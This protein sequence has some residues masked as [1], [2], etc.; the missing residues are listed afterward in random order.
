[1]IV[2]V[3]ADSLRVNDIVLVRAFPFDARHPR[4]VEAR[5]AAVERCTSLVRTDSGALIT[6]AA[7]RVRMGAGWSTVWLAA[8][9]VALVRRGT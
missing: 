1:M 9:G 4:F 7:V 2:S 8:E 6:S 5:V 3:R